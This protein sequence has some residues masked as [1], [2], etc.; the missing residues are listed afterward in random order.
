MADRH[1]MR[2]RQGLIVGLVV[3]AVLVLAVVAAVASADRSDDSAGAASS[4]VEAGPGPSPSQTATSENASGPTTSGSTTEPAPEP[5]SPGPVG[6]TEAGSL[7]TVPVEDLLVK[8]PVDLDEVGKFGTG[9][10]VKVVRTEA[11]AGEARVRGEIAGPAVRVT[12]KATNN[13][14]EE[15]S[16]ARS[17]VEVT[18]GETRVPGVVLSGPGVTEFPQ[19]LAPGESA[20]ATYVYGIPESERELVQIVVFYSTDAP[21]VVFEGAVP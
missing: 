9:L 11:V 8:E 13:T 14:D 6:P 19:S 17:Q 21:I 10:A 1:S 4:S 2:G 12:L 5:S 18:Y 15:V 3:V 7:E 20:R 16:L